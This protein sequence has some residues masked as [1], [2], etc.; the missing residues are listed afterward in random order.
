MCDV[1]SLGYTCTGGARSPAMA[2]SSLD[3][4]TGVTD[5]DGVS[6]DVCCT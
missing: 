4:G 6:T 5:P 2:D 3:C 1:G